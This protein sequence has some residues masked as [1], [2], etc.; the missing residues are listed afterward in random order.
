MTSKISTKRAMYIVTKLKRSQNDPS[1]STSQS[2]LDLANS[3]GYFALRAMTERL[4]RIQDGILSG[5]VK[6]SDGLLEEILELDSKLEDVDY[7][8]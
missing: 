5:R 8:K 7:L 2:T 3:N 4:E 6:M 1:S